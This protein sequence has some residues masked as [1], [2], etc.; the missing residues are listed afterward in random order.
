MVLCQAERSEPGQGQGPD[1]GRGGYRAVSSLPAQVSWQIRDQGRERGG[2]M[3]R[4]SAV[5]TSCFGFRIP[6]NDRK[7]IY[8]IS[9]LTRLRVA[10]A[11]TRQERRH[12]PVN[13]RSNAVKLKFVDTGR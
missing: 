5:L 1:C 11:E 4:A 13:V 3:P 6:G 8:A 9:P 7:G 12:G 10:G 2:T